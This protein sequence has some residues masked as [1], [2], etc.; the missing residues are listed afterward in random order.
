MMPYFKASG[1]VSN[2]QMHFKKGSAEMPMLTFRIIFAA[3]TGRFLTE[4]IVN[5]QQTFHFPNPMRYEPT[6]EM[7]YAEK[8]ET[9]EIPD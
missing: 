6:Q 7:I 1:D 5:E 3:E 4:N 9:G 8:L 2:T